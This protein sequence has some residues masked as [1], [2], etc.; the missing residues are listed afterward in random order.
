MV[1]LP[2]TKH[3]SVTK[4]SVGTAASFT[5]AQEMSI[6]LTEGLSSGKPTVEGKT[7]GCSQEAQDTVKVGTADS[8]LTPLY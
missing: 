7:T 4:Q 6:L 3:S 5:L 2:P 1:R 8:L